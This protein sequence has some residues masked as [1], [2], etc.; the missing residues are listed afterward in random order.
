MALETEV[1][2]VIVPGPFAVAVP[3]RRVDGRISSAHTVDVAMTPGAS[4][5]GV[6]DIMAAGAVFNV[7]S[8][9]VTVIQFPSHGGMAQ[10]NAA[11]AGV[12]VVAELLGVVAP[13]AISFFVTSV[14]TV[15]ELV[16][17]IMN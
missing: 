13:G 6:G 11:I 1:C 9:R 16:V 4:A 7:V 17:T 14:K 10:R 2:V 8:S 5:G 12:A 3:F 15:G